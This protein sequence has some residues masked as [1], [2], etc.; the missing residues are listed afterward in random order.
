MSGTATYHLPGSVIL[1]PSD[2][3]FVAYD[4]ERRR[5][6]RLNPTAGLLAELCDGSRT[7]GDLGT[8]LSPLVGTAWPRRRHWLD[9]AVE[10]GL[11]ATTREGPAPTAAELVRL[12]HRLQQRDE[13]LGAYICQRRATEIA[14]DHARHWLRLVE[15]AHITGRRQRPET[16]ISGI[17]TR[18]RTT[19]RSL[20][21]SRR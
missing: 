12:A 11:L 14:P 2:E 8:Q 7:V 5:L 6:H 17:S 3:G 1:A 21:W 18:I 4:T 15:L 13:V 16:P 9:E 20:T 10:N 19:P